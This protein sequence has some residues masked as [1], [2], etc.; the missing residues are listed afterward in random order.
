[1]AASLPG[2]FRKP[3]YL[4]AIMLDNLVGLRQFAIAAALDRK[5]D[6]NRPGLHRFDH[7][8]VTSFGAGRPGI[9]AVVM[10]MSCFAMCEATSAACFA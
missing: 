9:S 6:D 3:D 5:V 8:L 10:T 4:H 2:T 1:M 7:R